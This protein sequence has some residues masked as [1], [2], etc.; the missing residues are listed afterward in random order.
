MVETHGGKTMRARIRR[1][2][3]VFS[4]WGGPSGVVLGAIVIAAIMVALSVVS[5]YQGRLSAFE[6]DEDISKSLALI[7]ERD[8]TRNFEIYALSLQAVVDGVSSPVT[9]ALPPKV[10]QDVLFDRAT[11][12][13]YLG[14]VLVL[15][16]KGNIVLDAVGPVPRHGNFFHREYFQIHRD[17]PDAGL[18]I[19]DPFQ[20]QLRAGSPSIALSRRISRPD[21]SFAGIALMTI[22]LEYFHDLIAGLAL[23]PTGSKTLI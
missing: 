2:R 20:S 11:T 9:M 8:I 21:G 22:N 4:R 18:Y 3:S 7:A 13:Q 14:S 15:D 19:S 17:R 16:E 10:R 12:A 23:G 1:I 6:R 5:L